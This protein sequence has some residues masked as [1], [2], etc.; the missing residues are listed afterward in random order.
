MSRIASQ[1]K[2]VFEGGY[3]RLIRPRFDRHSDLDIG[4]VELG[5]VRDV[6]ETTKL[7]TAIYLAER[8]WHLEPAGVS[9]SL[10]LLEHAPPATLT[11]GIRTYQYR[12]SWLQLTRQSGKVA[13]TRASLLC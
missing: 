7:L 2:V 12:V 9:D 3:L 13:C 1:D 10:V 8:S 5:T 11:G 6:N 4:H